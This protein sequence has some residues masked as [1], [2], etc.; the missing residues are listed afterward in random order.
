MQSEYQS[1]IE[2]ELARFRV[3]VGEQARTF[4]A[5]FRLIALRWP[6]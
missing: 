6:F 4:F 3:E 5:E 1:R 2:L